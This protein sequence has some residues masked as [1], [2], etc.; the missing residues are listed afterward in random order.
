MK[1][2]L[3]FTADHHAGLGRLAGDVSLLLTVKNEAL[4][5]A[6]TRRDGVEGRTGWMFPATIQKSLIKTCLQ[7]ANAAGQTALESSK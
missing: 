1:D 7:G 5:P 2:C 3:E 4:H 6:E